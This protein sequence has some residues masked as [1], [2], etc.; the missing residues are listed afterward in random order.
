MTDI[1]ASPDAVVNG[2][3]VREY[4]RRLVD[5]NG[6]GSEYAERLNVTGTAN[7]VTGA[8]VVLSS[9]PTNLSANAD[10]AITFAV[11]V[12]HVYLQNNSGTAASV[13]FDATASLGAFLIPA[14]S[15]P[16]AFDF[17]CTVLHVYCTAALALNGTSGGNFVVR[18]RL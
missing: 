7:P 3:Y 1:I 16:I 14:G 18:G 13:D 10:T 8:S 6:D 4:P 9:P 2:K 11:P 5:V 17:P 15:P 12:N